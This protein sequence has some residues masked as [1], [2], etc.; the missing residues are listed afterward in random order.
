MAVRHTLFQQVQRVAAGAPVY[1]GLAVVSRQQHQAPSALCHLLS[2]VEK[3][4]VALLVD[5]APAVWTAF[6]GCVFD[7]HWSSFSLVQLLITG[8]HVL[9]LV[10]GAA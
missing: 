8:W 5:L 3:H 10:L 6:E 9:G 2:A 7:S 4:L 1:A